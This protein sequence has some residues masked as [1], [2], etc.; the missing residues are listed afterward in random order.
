[1][2]SLSKF[3]SNTPLP[4]EL[5][6]KIDTHFKYYWKHDRLSSL[7]ID[8]K[9]LQMMPKPLRWSLIEYLFD[10]IFHQFRGFLKMKDFKDA[11]D[12]DF[13]YE[14][15]FEFLPRKY[16]KNDVIISQGEDVQEI[17][18]IIQGELKIGF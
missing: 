7:T 1:M 11:K 4:Q 8:D 6:K 9:Y 16:E 15:A 12:R 18:F 14:L 17:Y 3:T 2:T 10:D 13:Y 5:V